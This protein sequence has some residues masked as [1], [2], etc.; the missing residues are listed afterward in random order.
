M[1]EA[2]VLSIR[3]QCEAA[4]VPFFFKQWGGVRK[5]SAGRSLLG[6]THDEIPKR[7]QHPTLPAR[8]R[9]LHASAIES[10]TLIQ[11]GTPPSTIN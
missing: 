7:V 5:K 9:L 10:G 11:L 6:R 1:K 3:E 2:W 4:N 8:L